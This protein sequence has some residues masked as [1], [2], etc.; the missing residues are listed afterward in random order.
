MLKK[1]FVIQ[2]EHDEK[3]DA[4]A[5]ELTA[6]YGVKVSRSDVLRKMIDAFILPRWS[7]DGSNVT[8]QTVDPSP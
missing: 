4:M 2:P 7:S 5:V 3:L 6:T 8:Q 1:I